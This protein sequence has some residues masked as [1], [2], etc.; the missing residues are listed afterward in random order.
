MAH[1]RAARLTLAAWQAGGL[2]GKREERSGLGAGVNIRLCVTG[3][4]VKG[5]RTSVG[6]GPGTAVTFVF[7]L[8][9]LVGGL[10]LRLLCRTDRVAATSL[11]DVCLPP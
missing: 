11:G 3:R 4:E 5:W 1:T 2:C 7:P 10:I 9:N 8:K 6:A